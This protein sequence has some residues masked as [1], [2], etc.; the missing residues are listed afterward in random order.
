MLD[1]HGDNIEQVTCE[2]KA[3]FSSN[4]WY[5][6]M[7]VAFYEYL[8]NSLSEIGNY[9]SPSAKT[10]GEKIADYHNLSVGSALVTNGA[11]EAFY[12]V[13]HLYQGAKSLIAVP[14]FAEYE[15]AC[16][17]Y[18]HS[19]EYVKLEELS[20]H[21]D[22]DTKMVWICNPNN[23]NGYVYERG[24]I[25][26]LLRTFPKTVF[27]VDE[28]YID[29]CTKAESLVPFLPQF[30]NLVIVKSMTKKFKIPGLRIGYILTSNDRVKSLLSCKMPWSVN[31]VAIAAGHYILDNECFHPFFDMTKALERSSVL[32]KE[33]NA[34]PGLSVLFNDCSFFIV[35]SDFCS[36]TELQQKLLYDHSVLVRDASNFR[37]LGNNSIRVAVQRKAENR[38]LVNALKNCT[39]K[40]DADAQ[41]KYSYSVIE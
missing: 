29:F 32:Q 37:G 19:I 41:G 14:S 1:G 11:T 6:K 25:V 36:A 34:I 5:E 24:V 18:S 3:N 7:P 27:L 21:V 40:I 35:Q 26:E 10:L 17:L 16:K 39:R 2:L 20:F 33:I 31:A 28:A 13:A 15:D 38:L 22:T 30:D 4:V 8:R 23:P 9:P 12:L